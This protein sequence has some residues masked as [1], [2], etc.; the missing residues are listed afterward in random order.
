MLNPLYLGENEL[1]LPVYEIKEGGERPLGGKDGKIKC[2]WCDRTLMPK[3]FI[4]KLDE[5]AGIDWAVLFCPK[6]TMAH[7][8]MKVKLLGGKSWVGKQTMPRVT[9]PFHPDPHHE[10]EVDCG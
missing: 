4:L 7:C 10:I 6:C 1:G 8:I 5:V 9:E 2:A 3:R